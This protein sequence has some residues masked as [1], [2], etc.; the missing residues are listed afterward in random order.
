MG[1]KR[2]Q[3]VEQANDIDGKYVGMVSG[4]A[5]A[6]IIGFPYTRIGNDKID[7]L[8]LPH[9]LLGIGT[10]GSPI[11]YVERGWH[12]RGAPCYTCCGC[13]G[14]QGLPTSN[15]TEGD[16]GVRIV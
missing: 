5:R 4:I 12:N 16:A 3:G 15:E 6:Q 13:G 9:K 11:A 10:H 8:C 14:E 2:E 7:A 1:N